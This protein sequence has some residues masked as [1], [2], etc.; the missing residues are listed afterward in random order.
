MRSGT[1]RHWARRLVEN[2]SA[3]RDQETAR[4]LAQH[5]EMHI[6]ENLKRGMPQPEARRQAL[7]KLGGFR[8][9]IEACRDVRLTRWPLFLS[10][11]AR[12]LHID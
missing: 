7:V 2:R 6:E 12:L 8:Q 4:E 3:A 5:L 11:V 1:L 10:R 9:T